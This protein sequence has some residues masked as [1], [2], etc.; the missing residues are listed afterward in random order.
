MESVEEDTTI[1]PKKKESIN[2]IVMLPSENCALS[3]KN[4]CYVITAMITD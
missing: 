3:L 1:F 2:S 4:Y